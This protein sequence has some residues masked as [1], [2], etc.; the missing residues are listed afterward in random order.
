[1]S[2]A[3]RRFNQSDLPY[4]T[5][6]LPGVGG[7]IKRY[8]EDFVVTEIP[9][10]APS[11]AGTHVY[12]GVEKHSL[13]TRDAISQIARGLGRPRMDIGYAGL[14]DAHAVTRQTF[15]VEHIDPKRI[16][17]FENSRMRVLWISRHTNKIKLGH[18]AGNRFRIR[19][20]DVKSDALGRAQS[21]L[22][23]LRRRGVPNYFEAQRFGTRGDNALVGAAILRN[24]F[25]AALKLILGSPTADDRPDIARARTLCDAGDYEN[26]ARA[27]PGFC[28]EQ[29]KLC[30][31]LARGGGNAKKAW[32]AVDHTLRKLYLSAIQSHVFNLVLAMRIDQIYTLSDGD[33]AFKHANGAT[34][35]VE[36]AATEQPRCDAFEISPT[37]PLFGSRMKQAAGRPAELERSV[38]AATGLDERLFDYR[39]KF[40]LDG[41]R[42]PLRVPLENPK[43]ASGNDANGAYLELSF[44]LPPGSYATCVTREI[45]KSAG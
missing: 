14:K 32:A 18:L 3:I 26:A 24:D 23:V 31:I 2:D 7:E 34:F 25:E 33:V 11:G 10:Y 29:Q 5:A 12:F 28:H 39:E 17:R 16:E 36:S 21:I 13:T 42:R 27:W 30:K 41:S 9:L 1:M 35:N 37:G 40:R 6:E 8:D 15:S 20:R 19:I 43:A 38:L 4:L 45:C 22:D 44:T